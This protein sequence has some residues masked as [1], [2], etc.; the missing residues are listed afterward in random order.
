M[1]DALTQRRILI[2]GHDTFRPH[3]MIREE[4][5]PVVTAVLQ[6]HDVVHWVDEETISYDI[7]PPI[8]FVYVS[9]GADLDAVQRLLDSI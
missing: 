6:D 9:R 4:Q 7:Q 1:I 3:F 5:L 8:A 2:Y